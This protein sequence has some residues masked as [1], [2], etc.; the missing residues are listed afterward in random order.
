MF[1][2]DGWGL[3]LQ[4]TIDI[5]SVW[6]GLGAEVVWW[7]EI[8]ALFALEIFGWEGRDFRGVEVQALTVLRVKFLYLDIE[9]FFTGGRREV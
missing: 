8:P 9:I 7:K 1:N 6:F 4:P 3:R 2:T 5:S